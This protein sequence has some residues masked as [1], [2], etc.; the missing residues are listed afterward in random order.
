MSNIN[1]LSLF[2]IFLASLIVSVLFY[3]LLFT[4]RTPQRLEFTLEVAESTLNRSAE[5]LQTITPISKKVE[6]WTNSM[7]NN[8]YSTEAYKEAI[9][10]AGEAGIMRVLLIHCQG[11]KMGFFI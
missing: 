9:L 5:V 3:L 7:R 6:K 8:E 10:S 2:E 1:I 4:D 11:I